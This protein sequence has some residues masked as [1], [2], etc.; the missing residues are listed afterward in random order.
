VS[1]AG[2]GAAAGPASR[3]ASRAAKAKAV[4]KRAVSTRTD[5]GIR[6]GISTGISTG[7]GARVYVERSI[8]R[9]GL[10]RGVGQSVGRVAGR[11][12]GRAE[13]CGVRQGPVGKQTAPLP[14]CA[15]EHL[16]RLLRRPWRRRSGAA[17]RCRR[18]RRC[19]RGVKKACGGQWAVGTAGR[20]DMRAVEWVA[21]SQVTGLVSCSLVNGGLV[22]EG[23]RVGEVEATGDEAAGGAIL[24]QLLVLVDWLVFDAVVV[25]DA[26]ANSIVVVKTGNRSQRAG[27]CCGASSLAS[28][29]APDG[30]PGRALEAPAGDAGGKELLQLVE[31]CA[32]PR[33][34]ARLDDRGSISRCD[35]GGEARS[36]R[37]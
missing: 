3:A 22:E 35:R 14:C 37:W 4:E 18:C 15:C 2:A 24:V 36:N 5:C 31:G 13:G 26:L 21:M 7:L 29:G 16:I 20:L 27:A 6:A 32:G 1:G 9:R 30:T 25:L 33:R 23:R 8:H 28:A 11:A 17:E 12:G 10:G 34:H 19:R